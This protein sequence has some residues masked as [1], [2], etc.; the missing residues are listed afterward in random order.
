M[1]NLSYEELLELVLSSGSDDIKLFTGRFDGGKWIQQVP[2][3]IAGC[4]SYL[5]QNNIQIKTFVE[6]GTAS[7]GTAWLVD[8]VLEPERIFLLDDNKHPRWIHRKEVLKD[9]EYEIFIGDSQ[10]PE[11]VKFL[12]DRNVQADLILIDADHSYE[13]VKRDTETMMIVSPD[14]LFLYHDTMV[15]GGI[16]RHIAEEVNGGR[17]E[18][19][20][21]FHTKLGLDLCKKCK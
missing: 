8:H 3:E 12:Q 1:K 10:S 6:C 15:C 7:G 4:L 17:M 5:I 16:S 2:E 21:T 14:A 11:A 13:G 9:V 19:V 20:K 18:V